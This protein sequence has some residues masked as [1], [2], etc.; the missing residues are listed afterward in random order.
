M[1]DLPTMFESGALIAALAGSHPALR[2]LRRQLEGLRIAKREHTGVGFFAEL[3]VE[4]ASVMPAIFPPR[5]TIS[6]VDVSI[7]GLRTGAGIVLFVDGG[8]LT[9]L[10]GFTYDE[11]WPDPPDAYSFAYRDPSRSDLYKQLDQ[12]RTRT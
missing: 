8:A 10:E 6:D 3:A 1:I 12:I 4:P 11:P 2:L 5:L 7:A 9:L